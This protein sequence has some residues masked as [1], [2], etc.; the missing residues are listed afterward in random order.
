LA[1]GCAQGGEAIFKLSWVAV[2]SAFSM[3][4]RAIRLG[5]LPQE[6]QRDAIL[7]EL[8]RLRPSTIGK[9]DYMFGYSW[10]AN[11]FVG[12]NKHCFAAGQVRRFATEMGKPDG[13]V[14]FAG[15]HLRRLEHGMESAM[16][17]S[18][19]AAFEVLERG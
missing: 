11:R 16:E 18:E 17:T 12:G 10:E 8:N 13:R 1:G 19:I 14:H 7:A 2:K 15:E 9:L 3:A 6:A 5:L 4:A